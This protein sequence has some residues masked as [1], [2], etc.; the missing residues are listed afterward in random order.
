[1][2]A[3][4]YDRNEIINDFLSHNFSQSE[5]ARFYDAKY[6]KGYLSS[7]TISKILNN[8]NLPQDIRAKIA[9]KKEEIKASI[10]DDRKELFSKIDLEL[11]KIASVPSFVNDENMMILRVA[12]LYISGYSYSKI[13]EMIGISKS[14]VSSYINAA[15]NMV[16]LNEVSQLLLEELIHKS[17]KFNKN[18][19]DEDI[20]KAVQIFVMNNG[21]YNKTKLET[22]LAERTLSRYFGTSNLEEV[23]NDSELYKQ[24]HEVTSRQAKQRSMIASAASAHKRKLVN[25]LDKVTS[26][27]GLKFKI[28]LKPILIDDITDIKVLQNL[29]GIQYQI[30]KEYLTK[31][32]E[33]R[34]LFGDYVYNAFKSKKDILL[35]DDEVVNYDQNK[36]R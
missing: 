23:L 36:K 26:I 24:F 16:I 21:D 11:P 25:D 14:T 27:R 29:L 5:L 3:L 32:D 9:A 13:S 7:Q 6:Y 31:D 10:L 28:M 30:I 15:A 1:M 22:G 17:S 8:K 34:A 2:S 19:T 35:N 20:K 18:S 4:I 12:Y 33:I